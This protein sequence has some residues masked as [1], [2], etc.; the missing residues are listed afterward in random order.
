MGRTLNVK[1]NG[2]L[3]CWQTYEQFLWNILT[4]K[5]RHPFIVR[6]L[7]MIAMDGNKCDAKQFRHRFA[8]M[9]ISQHD[10]K[11]GIG[12]TMGLAKGMYYLIMN[13]VTSMQSKS[14]TT[15]TA[16]PLSI[17]RPFI[18]TLSPST[19]A[20]GTGFFGRTC[21][22]SLEGLNCFKGILEN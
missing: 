15:E 16:W 14:G 19:R 5:G 6:S 11:A 12:K 10:I 8:I 7:K 17:F 18:G 20:A 22:H 21:F 2:L 1:K 13:Y 9:N 3:I 4:S